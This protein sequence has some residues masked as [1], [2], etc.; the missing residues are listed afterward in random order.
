MKKN[1][2]RKALES[3]LAMFEETFFDKTEIDHYKSRLKHHLQSAM[4]IEGKI[5]EAKDRFRAN[6]DISNAIR[7]LLDLPISQ[8]D[9]EQL[10]LDL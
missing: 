2:D 4:E 9:P 6:N 3:A 7:E 1:L 10:E 8:K 5:K